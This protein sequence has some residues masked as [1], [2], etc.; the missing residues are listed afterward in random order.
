MLYCL[1]CSKWAYKTHKCDIMSLI[2]LSKE[3]KG[4]ADKM[5]ALGLELLSA[6]CFITPVTESFYD[7]RI[8]F[9]IEL[10]H[11]IPVSIFELPE[12][13]SYYTEIVGIDIEVSAINYSEIYTWTPIQSPSKQ[14]HC[15][16]LS[17]ETYL[18]NTYDHAGFKAVRTLY[19]DDWMCS[20]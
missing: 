4:L 11:P 14:A 2:P 19:S 1:R 6:G 9:D 13:W 20:I 18:T 17:L 10:R 12:G 16:A 5:Y 15:I 7:H 8:T 3:C